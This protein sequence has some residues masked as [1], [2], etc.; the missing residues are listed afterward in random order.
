MIIVYFDCYMK[1]NI[2]KSEDGNLSVSFQN[3]KQVCICYSLYPLLQ[4]LL[5]MDEEI[6]KKHTCYFLGSEIPYNIRRQLPCYCYETR[7]AKTLIKKIKRVGEKLLLRI[8]RF[9]KYPF[10]K[11]VRFF[12]QDF[13]YLSILIGDSQYSMLEEAPNH[14][15]YVGKENSYIFQQIKR[16]SKTLKGK[17]E[18]FFYGQIATRYHGYNDQ[19]KEFYLTGETE[20]LAIINKKTHID[21]LKSLWDKSTE[22]KRNFILSVFDLTNEDKVLL[23]SYPIIFISQPWVSDSYV[24]EEDYVQLLQEVFGNY[25]RNDIIIK[26]HPRDYFD[27]KKYFPDIK[28]FTKPI[29]MQLM[30]LVMLDVKKVV[31]FTSTAVYC[32]PKDVEIDWYGTPEHK[33]LK[34]VENFIPIINRPYNKIS[35]K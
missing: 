6:I 14:L 25:D 29:S 20:A 12:A 15:N 4:Y 19:C 22:K 13:G 34:P 35:W 8:T 26:C 33:L 17:I 30:M 11:N 23:A 32:M 2:I 18:T 28:V 21:S 27:Y 3:V 10:L 1:N 9:C 16:K 31:T 5:L 24:R 7:P